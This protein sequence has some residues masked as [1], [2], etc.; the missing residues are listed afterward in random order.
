MM[1]ILAATLLSLSLVLL[2]GCR[3]KTDV[4]VCILD[5]DQAKLECVLPSGEFTMVEVKDAH[6]YA[7]LSN[8]DLEKL[9]KWAEKKCRK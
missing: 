5:S 2:T 8:D 4:T 6:N 7:C 1:R 9:L 3:E